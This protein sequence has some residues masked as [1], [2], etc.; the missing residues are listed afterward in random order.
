MEASTVGNRSRKVWNKH[1]TSC[2]YDGWMGERQFAQNMESTMKSISMCPSLL[3][4]ARELQIATRYSPK[5][6]S[7]VCRV[8]S[9]VLETA[10]NETRVDVREGDEKQHRHRPVH[11][12]A[13]NK[14]FLFY[15]AA[16]KQPT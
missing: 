9:Q 10:N 14:L 7:T 1:N 5:V 2:V 13:V 16:A 3:F 12:D 4:E 15:E 8:T 6:L 11:G